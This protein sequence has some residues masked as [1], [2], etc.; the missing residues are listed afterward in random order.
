MAKY[1]GEQGPGWETDREWRR[2]GPSTL[3]ENPPYR[4]PNIRI[5]WEIADHSGRLRQGHIGM[6]EPATVKP[7]RG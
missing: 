6:E 2:P 4:K 3:R 1:Q 7:P 5:F